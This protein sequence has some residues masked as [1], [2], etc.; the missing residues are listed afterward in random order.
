TLRCES[1]DDH[2]VLD[3]ATQ[4]NL[5]LV[6]SPGARDTSLLAVLD[7]TVTPMGGRKLRSWILQPLRDLKELNHRQQMIADL[8]HESDLLGS[9]R[10]TLKSIRD[11]ERAAGRLSQVSGNAR[12]LVTLKNSLQQIPELK[13]ELQKLIERVNFGKS[14]SPVEA[15]VPAAL[16]AGVAELRATRPPLQECQSLAKHLQNDI[17]EMPELAAKLKNALFDDAPLALKEGG[18]F[19]DGFDPQLDELRNASRE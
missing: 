19:H 5:D 17:A 9:L 14:D 18:I 6:E 13:E 16:R 2:V 11:V 12:D 7:R 1:A 8:L 3:S 15:A 4:T 10:H